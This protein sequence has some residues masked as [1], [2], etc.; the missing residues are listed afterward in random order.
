MGIRSYAHS[1]M[2]AT[3]IAATHAHF[4]SLMH[5]D[6][7]APSLWNFIQRGQWPQ[8]LRSIGGGHCCLGRT[9]KVFVA[10]RSKALLLNRLPCLA[11]WS[12]AYGQ[13]DSPQR[14][15]LRCALEAGRLSLNDAQDVALRRG[16]TCLSR[17]YLNNRKHLMWRCSKGHEWLASLDNVKNG[18]RWCPRCAGRMP[19]SLEEAQAVARKRGGT[20]LSNEYHNNKKPLEWRCRQ[21]HVWSASLNNVKDKGRWCWQC[22][23]DA[24]RLSLKLAQDVAASRGGTCLSTKY[25]NCMK[26]LK[27]RCGRGHEW[28]ASPSNTKA[29]GAGSV[30]LKP[31]VSH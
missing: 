20:C 10:E 25:V 15:R 5:A 4:T 14:L 19:L 21:G 26:R 7:V 29:D 12:R 22:A 24:K 23:L 2:A 6:C 31:N 28:L 13:E 3:H 8:S 16:G 9:R 27:W 18:G 30:L 1:G 11:G 17:T